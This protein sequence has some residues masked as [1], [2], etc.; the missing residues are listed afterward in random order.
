MPLGAYTPNTWKYGMTKQFSFV[1][2]QNLIGAKHMETWSDEDVFPPSHTKF[3]GIQMNNGHPDGGTTSAM[4]AAGVARW[5][6]IQSQLE[7]RC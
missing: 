4:R 1:L 5:I 2:I 7:L 6:I 3:D